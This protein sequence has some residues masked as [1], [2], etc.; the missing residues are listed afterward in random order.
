V[1]IGCGR[2]GSLF[3]EQPTVAGIQTHAG[4]Y[5]HCAQTILVGVCDT[6]ASRR[7]ACA[8]FWSVPSY[9]NVEELLDTQRPELVSVCG[10]DATHADTIHAALECPSVRGV[11]VEKPLALD[12]ASARSAVDRAQRQGVAIVVNYTRR[13]LP[14]FTRLQRWLRDGG[15]GDLQLAHGVYVKGL[16]HNGTHWLDL[17]R[18]LVGEIGCVA[19]RQRLTDDP[20][21]PSLDVELE[22]AGGGAGSL[23]AL[24]SAQFSIFEIDL[25]GTRGRVRI[26]DAG[27]RFEFHERRASPVFA[28]YLELQPTS[29]PVEAS[30]HNAMLFVVEDL[31]RAIDGEPS[32]C[33]GRDGVRAIELVEAIRAS[34]SGG[35][36]RRFPL[37]S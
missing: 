4:A 31:L 12:S 1:I 26:T 9:S 24:D 22:F 23:M 34:A 29:A 27:R 30:T 25:I 14:S 2:I 36:Q 16:M 18:Y 8:T 37:D 13:F 5:R 21:D 10:P 15:I 33:A 17:A 19:G 35:G 11:L 6:N 7:D 3:D 32:Q 28:G 20:C